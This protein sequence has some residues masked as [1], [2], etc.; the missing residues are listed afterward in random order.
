MI[1]KRNQKS[2][3]IFVISSITLIIGLFVFALGITFADGTDKF[4]RREVTLDTESGMTVQQRTV[5]FSQLCAYLEAYVPTLYKYEELY[6]ISYEETKAYYG[7]LVSNTEND[8]EYC[9]AVKG[10]LNNIP[11]AH[12]ASGFPSMSG[13]DEDFA[14]RLAKNKSFVNAQD[15]WF[16]VLHDEC[17]KHYDKEINQMI[18]AYYSGEY[19]GVAKPVDNDVY[20]VNKATLL[21]VNGVSADEFVK[22]TPS[23]SKLKYDHANQKPMRD[24]IIF[25]DSFGE[26]CTVEY[27]DQ[28]G[29]KHSAKMY[30]GAE[31]DLAITYTNYFKQLDGLAFG[32]TSADNT[33]A[34]KADYTT[35]GDMTVIRSEERDIL[36]VRIDSFAS[37]NSNGEVMAS[38]IKSSSEG[39]DNIIIDIRGNRGG[40]YEWAN[41]VL[42]AL[43]QK[44]IEIVSEV[45]I[46]QASYDRCEN[47]GAYTFDETAG[48]YKTCI[49]ETVKGTADESKNIYLLVSDTT[50]SAADN[51][52]YELGKNAIGTVIGVNNTAGERDGTICLSYLDIS[53]IYFTYT[54]YAAVDLGGNC[55]SVY[56]TAPDIYVRQ[57]VE[58]YFIREEIKAEGKDPNNLEN[59]LKYDSVLIRTLELINEKENT[60]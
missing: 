34:E 54:E 36:F 14:S 35:V 3:R 59:R 7:K 11:S 4:Y 6:G 40:Y 49:T 57:T 55:S 25:N 41:S 30:Y 12:M 45:Y 43:S 13:I 58:D 5:D 51:L 10:F 29:E 50:G 15:Y 24:T 33:P 52:A 19:R 56:G 46:T 48:L 53:G 9:A 8:F 47:K 16:G 21:T 31:A 37:Q 18:F 26:E 1:K 60:E 20:G 17:R 27:L 42:G 22:L 32:N 39:I 44:D 28:Q 38:V 2:F 23:V